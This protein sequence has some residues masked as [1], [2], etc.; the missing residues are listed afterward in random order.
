[1]GILNINLRWLEAGKP[2]D[3]WLSHSPLRRACWF[4]PLLPLGGEALD[5]D[6]Q[7]LDGNVYLI[8]WQ[9]YLLSKTVT[10]DYEDSAD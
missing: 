7:I 6:I 8:K 2:M 10:M 9:F 4:N 3:C 1:M 5:E